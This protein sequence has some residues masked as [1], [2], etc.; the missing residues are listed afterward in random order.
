[1]GLSDSFP[2]FPPA[3]WFDVPPDVRPGQR[4]ALVTEGE[5]AGRFVAIVAPYNQCILAGGKRGECWTAPK[6]PTNYAAAMQGHTRTAEG[7]DIDTANIGGGVNHAPPTAG[8]NQAV[9]HYANTATQLLRVRYHDV[10]GVGIVAAGAAWPGISDL[11]IAKIRASALSGDWRWREE[12]R[13]YDMA[14]SQLVSTPGFPRMPKVA[15]YAASLSDPHPAILGGWGGPPEEAHVAPEPTVTLTLTA[16]ETARLH[17]LLTGP[18][19]GVTNVFASVAE[20]GACACGGHTAAPGDA[21]FEAAVGDGAPVSRAEF[22]ALVL[23]VEEVRGQVMA[24]GLDEVDGMVAA[25]PQPPWMDDERH[26]MPPK[27][28]PAE[29]PEDGTERAEDDEEKRKQVT[30]G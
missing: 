4:A 11:D 21:E 3:D 28:D 10:P 20:P 22:D 19:A 12:L 14:G 8:L 13:A 9:D 2:L 24:E 23:Q 6:S 7:A 15:A 25:M 5:E 1:M 18:P 30:V 29:Q 26:K 16:T 27:D 17:E